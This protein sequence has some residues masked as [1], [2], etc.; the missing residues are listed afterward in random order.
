MSIP[1]QGTR[2]YRLGL[3]MESKRKVMEA[4]GWVARRTAFSPDGHWLAYASTESGRSEIYV[5][6]FPGPGGKWQ[7]SAAGGVDPRWRGDGKELFYLSLDNKIMAVP[8]EAA[9]AFHAG[10]P[11]ALFSVHPQG[12]GSVYDVAA[13][14]KRF[15]VNRLPADQG[16]PPLSLLVNWTSLLKP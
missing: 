10:T 7:V 16:S 5:R 1:A 8:L 9:P 3:D 15:F 13:D 6:A 12:A 11:V 4:P 14:G 2:I